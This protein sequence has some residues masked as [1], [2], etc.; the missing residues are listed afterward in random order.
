MKQHLMAGIFFLLSLILSVGAQDLSYLY[1]VAHYTLINTPDDALGLQAPVTL[2]NAPYSGNNGVYSNGIY[3]GGDPDGCIIQTPL[4]TTLYDSIFAIRLEFNIPVLDGD[5][6]AI[7]VCGGSYRYLGFMVR[8]DSI[9]QILYNNAYYVDITSVFPDENVWHE[10]TIIHHAQTS[11]T[12]FYL[13]GLWIAELN[14]PFIRPEND[15]N[16]FNIHPGTGDTFLGYW[17]NLKVFGSEFISGEESQPKREVQWNIFP[18][19]AN[20]ILFTP[21]SA[22]EFSAWTVVNI[23]G[24]PVLKGTKPDHEIVI[25]SLD[26]GIYFLY[27]TD[28]AEFPI[29]CKRF[30]K[31]N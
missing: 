15:G 24:I 17:R 4:F 25:S 31:P 22:F 7:L 23:L 30:V 13:D 12:E 2:L 28:Q 29:I 11:Y 26:P 14:E 10:L 9:F 18:N 27:L 5:T 16:I 20:N 21:L 19:P 6:R 8:Y 3:P 1:P